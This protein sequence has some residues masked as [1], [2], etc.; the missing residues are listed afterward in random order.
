MAAFVREG[1]GK[2]LGPAA[3]TIHAQALRS[4]VVA[5]PGRGDRV[6]PLTTKVSQPDA[7]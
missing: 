3:C 4:A 5:I 6:L 1:F 7:R 2:D